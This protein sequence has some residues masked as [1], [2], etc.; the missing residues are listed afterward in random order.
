[1]GDTAEGGASSLPLVAPREMAL[2]Q[3]KLLGG[4]CSRL[5]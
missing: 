4:G 5:I 2:D 1:M 3:S